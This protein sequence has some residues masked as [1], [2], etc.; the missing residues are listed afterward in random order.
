MWVAIIQPTEDL[1]RTKGE[2]R[3]ILFPFPY[4]LAFLALQLIDNLG[5]SLPL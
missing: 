2:G 4:L 1:H 3:R 5:T